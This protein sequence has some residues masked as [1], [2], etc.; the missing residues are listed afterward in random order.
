M[1]YMHHGVCSDKGQG[2]ALQSDEECQCLSWPLPFVIERG[3]DSFGSI[4]VWRK[5]YQRYQDSEK[6]QNMHDQDDDFD[7]RQCAAYEHVDEDTQHQ[8][9]P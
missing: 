1:T 9:S 7:G 3:E 4:V 5:I 6:A 8:H 2:I